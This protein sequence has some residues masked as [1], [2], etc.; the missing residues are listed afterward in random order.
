MRIPLDEMVQT[1]QKAFELAGLNAEKAKKCAKIH[2]ESSRDGVY[3][4]G[5][6]RV[7]RFID[8]IQQ[9]WIQ[10]E[11]EP[12]LE[13]NLGAIEIYQG[14]LAPG[15]LNASFAMDRATEIA[16]QFGIGLVAMN[17]TNHWMRGGTYGWQA[18][19]KGFIG[20]CWTNT[21]SCMPS[22][23][24][25]TNNIGNNPFVIAIP[26]KEGHVVLDMAMSLYS[27]GKLEVTRQKGQ[28]LPYPG[29]FDQQGNLTVEPSEIELT[30]RIL[31]T[32]YWKGSSLAIMLDLL[33]GIL[34]K[35]KTTAEIDQFGKGNSVGL[36]QVFI[37]IDP[38]KMVDQPFI[39]QAL[40]ATIEQ[41][42]NST[43]V[44]ESGEVLYP[45][46]RSLRTRMENLQSGI[47]VDEQVWQNV[48]KLA[49]LV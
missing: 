26:R 16:V 5:L 6:N 11:A 29:G 24:S 25:L 42:R 23:G 28:Q 30:R 22:W 46:E 40:M 27:Y 32:G 39:D 9:G 37:A 35:G 45:G 21:E 33:A 34:S 36:S 44:E 49:G 8:Y 15:V 19:D 47:P 2:A 48:R 20:I 10:L 41:L 7:A 18:A 38:L 1:I 17:H 14:N 31:P 12:S 43:S 13:I 4:H 3:S